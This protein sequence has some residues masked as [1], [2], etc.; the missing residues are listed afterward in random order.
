MG[1]NPIS[2]TFVFIDKDMVFIFMYA[3]HLQAEFWAKWC[4]FLSASWRVWVQI[5]VLAPFLSIICILFFCWIFMHLQKEVF[6]VLTNC[7]FI[8]MVVRPL[9]ERNY[10]KEKNL[11]SCYDARKPKKKKIKTILCILLCMWMVEIHIHTL[12]A[13]H[14]NR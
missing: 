10:I 14:T 5:P 2:D 7:T 3:T 12:K 6:A 4:W 1:S 8:E 9:L 13:L 11:Q